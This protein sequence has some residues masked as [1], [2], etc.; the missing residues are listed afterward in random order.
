MLVVDALAR[1]ETR[2][3]GGASVG[4]V[5]AALQVAHS[6]AS[7]LVER[8]VQAGMVHRTRAD[9]DP[10]R[11]LLRLTPAGEELQQTAIR[12][13]TDR[14][15]ALTYNWAAEDVHTLANLL[16]RFARAVQSPTPPDPATPR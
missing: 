3:A 6:T 8:A 4:Q 11:A 13:R 7:R 9:D 14:L 5:A 10:R 15:A 2:T 16:E 1:S 12:F